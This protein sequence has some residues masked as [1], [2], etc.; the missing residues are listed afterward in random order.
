MRT[1]IILSLFS[2]LLTN[3]VEVETKQGFNVYYW[4]STE[5][6]AKNY[7]YIDDKKIGQL[8]YLAFYPECGDE[9]LKQTLMVSV[10]SGK[11]KVVVKD[12]SGRVKFSKKFKVHVSKSS[13]QIS[14]SIGNKKWNSVI[15]QKGTC[16][17]D[18]IS[19]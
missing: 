3:C 16:L 6:T 12:E 8:P 2:I 10:E 13:T 9:A 1:V 4:T 18:E 19:F 5:D 7:L 15:R 11:Y 14:T 17:V